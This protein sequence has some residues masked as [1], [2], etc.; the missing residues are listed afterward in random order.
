M[1]EDESNKVIENEQNP[2]SK[3]QDVISRYADV[4]EINPINLPSPHVGI[5]DVVKLRDIIEKA[6][7][8]GN[9]DGF[10]LP[11]A[12]ILWRKQLIY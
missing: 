7:Q 6:S 10:V 8:D 2:I 4:T 11:M 12:Q 1:S 9:Y 5:S 3:H